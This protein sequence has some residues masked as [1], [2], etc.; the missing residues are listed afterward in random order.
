MALAPLFLL[1]GI[2][3]PFQLSSFV[4][5]LEFCNTEGALWENK[6]LTTEEGT[7]PFNSY[8]LWVEEGGKKA[9]KKKKK[10]Q[11]APH[12]I[13]WHGYIPESHLLLTRRYFS[14]VFFKKREKM[15]VSQFLN[16]WL[17]LNIRYLTIHSI[18]K[19]CYW[20]ALWG[21]RTWITSAL[22][23]SDLSENIPFL[24]TYFMS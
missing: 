17:F 2:C 20:S 24:P 10:S 16:I 1:V 14:F 22:V 11:T 15:G 8:L 5:A 21:M 3:I 23:E 19:I 7:S 18:G 9:S 13:I 4:S 6:C 12:Q